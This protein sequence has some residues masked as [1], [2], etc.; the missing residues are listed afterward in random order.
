MYL[1]FILLYSGK[2]YKF[3]NFKE[4]TVLF[5]SILLIIYTAIFV[6]YNYTNL[7]KYVYWLL[8][9]FVVSTELVITCSN[10]IMLSENG[11]TLKEDINLYKPIINTIL[12]NENEFYRIEKISPTSY[13]DGGLIDYYGIS[14]FSSM[15][16]EDVSRL[17]RKLGIA[18][19]DIN[20]YY[21]NLQTPVYNSIFNIKYLVGDNLDSSHHKNIAD[22]IYEYNFPLSI[23]FAVNQNIKNWDINSFNPMYIQNNFISNAVGIN[24]IFEIIE[25]V[26]I[27]CDIT[28]YDDEYVANNSK[29]N[30]QLTAKKD[31]YIYF[32]LN[33]YD[34][35]ALSINGEEI[36]S[37]NE[38]YIVNAGFYEKEEQVNIEAIFSNDIENFFRVYASTLNMN[39]F[40]NAYNILNEE[41]LNIESFKE[42]HIKGT[43]N[44]DKEKSVFT[45]IPYDEGWH[46]YVDGTETGFYKIGNSLIGFDIATGFHE[47]EFKYS[48]KGLYL[49]ITISLIS[50]VTFFILN[51]KEVLYF[52]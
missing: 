46:V 14:I 23:A 6:L 44:V 22:K 4:D 27:D 45:S 7:N 10:S 48:P 36:Y 52:N 31:G 28:I 24:D 33:S 49:G 42:N 43:I 37:S 30:I 47:V 2:I 17:Q 3:E 25:P 40:I 32:Y 26:F 29:I 21:Y 15:A 34:S 35:V 38:P 18:G 1:L 50:L 8:I 41:K 39:N 13:N 5:N 9:V 12:P 20:S 51:K 11:I 19:N 16:Y